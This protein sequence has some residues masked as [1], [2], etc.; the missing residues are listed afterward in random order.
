M[1]ISTV[2]PTVPTTAPAPLEPVKTNVNQHLTTNEELNKYLIEMKI[3]KPPHNPSAE[4]DQEKYARLGYPEGHWMGV[5]QV[6]P[7]YILLAFGVGC[8]LSTIFQ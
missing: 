1:H 6:R 3:S 7:I 8:L 5:Q 2:P 4:T